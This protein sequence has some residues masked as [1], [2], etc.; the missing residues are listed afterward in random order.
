MEDGKI[1]VLEYAVRCVEYRYSTKTK[2]TTGEANHQS[3]TIAPIVVQRWMVMG[4]REKLIELLDEYDYPSS[5]PGIA[6]HLITNGVT[7]PVRCKDCIYWED[8][9]LGYC[10]KHH[11]SMEFDDFCSY[12]ERK[13]D[14]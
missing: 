10:P 6:D 5:N 8:G 12:G 9:Y 3:L 4:M 2:T 13:T 7:I 11:I 1:T 14:D